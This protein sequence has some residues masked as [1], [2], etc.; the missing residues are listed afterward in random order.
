MFDVIFKGQLLP[1]FEAEQPDDWEKDF[2]GMSADEVTTATKEGN[3]YQ[4]LNLMCGTSVLLPRCKTPEQE[5]YVSAHMG[6][7]RYTF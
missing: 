7:V 4:A 6:G 5:I 2:R 1:G 3:S